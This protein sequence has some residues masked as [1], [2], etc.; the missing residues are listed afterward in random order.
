MDSRDGR[1]VLF[2]DTMIS[3][4]EIVLRTHSLH[5]IDRAVAAFAAEDDRDTWMGGCTCKYLAHLADLQVAY[6]YVTCKL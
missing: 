5:Q 4:H 3:C 2:G 6:K 1:D